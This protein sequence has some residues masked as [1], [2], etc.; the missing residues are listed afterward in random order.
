MAS[1]MLRAA[2][3]CAAILASSSTNP[4][5]E[6]YL[7]E[8]AKKEGVVVMPSGLQYEVVKSGPASAARPSKSDQCTCHYTGKL[9]DGTVFDSSVARGQ[10]ATFSPGGVIGGWTEA[11]MLMRPGDKW[12][13]AIPS[14]SQ[15][16]PA[17]AALHAHYTRTR[18]L[19]LTAA[20]AGPC[21][22]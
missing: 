16:D 15:G 11:L 22:R 10:P 13:L 17:T 21:I 19:L 5:G 3:L 20:A 4:A 2:S 1:K 8:N 12:I 14:V 6:A 18:A 7:A 9:I